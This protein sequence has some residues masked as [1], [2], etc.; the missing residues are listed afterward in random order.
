[1]TKKLVFALDYTCLQVGKIYT[2]QTGRS[3]EKR[4]KEHFY[5]FKNSNYN[6]IFSQY[7]LENN[8]SFGKMED[9]MEV[10]NYNQK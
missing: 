4:F 5:S 6:S 1:M 2:G 3:F 9:I 10:V 7:I 8:K